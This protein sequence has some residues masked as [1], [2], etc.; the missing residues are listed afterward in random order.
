M[1]HICTRSKI[2]SAAVVSYAPAVNLRLKSAINVI[3]FNG[4]VHGLQG[5]GVHAQR[6]ES[7]E[8]GRA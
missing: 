7:L 3:A 2:K 1:K 4:G 5:T 6:G 8:F